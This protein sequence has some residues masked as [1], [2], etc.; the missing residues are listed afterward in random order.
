MKGKFEEDLS[1]QMTMVADLRNM[2]RNWYLTKN[3]I[4]TASNFDG[5]VKDLH[6]KHA[7]SGA[8][9]G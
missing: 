3:M 5:L 1:F 9:S 6:L 7:V 8:E 2:S 4:T